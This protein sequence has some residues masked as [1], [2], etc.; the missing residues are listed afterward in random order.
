MKCNIFFNGGVDI[1]NETITFKSNHNLTDGQLI[2]YGSNGNSPIGI[3]TAF[4]LENKISG[5]VTS[6]INKESLFQANIKFSGHTEILAKFTNSQN[7]A[8]LLINKEIKT[9]LSTIH[10]SLGEVV[11]KISFESQISSIN[12]AHLGCFVPMYLFTF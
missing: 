2:Y 3:G 8:M 12:F 5:I 4:D 1:V 6:P 11:N 9:L 10:C 7:V